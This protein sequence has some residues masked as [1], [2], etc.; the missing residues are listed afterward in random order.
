M[1]Y[2]QELTSEAI[3]WDSL[4]FDEED[5]DRTALLEALPY[6]RKY[7]SRSARAVEVALMYDDFDGAL[8]I[9]VRAALVILVKRFGYVME[10]DDERR[11]G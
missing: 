3:D 2:A 1:A 11:E 5:P 10:D 6:I 8:R 9:G 7:D 4:V